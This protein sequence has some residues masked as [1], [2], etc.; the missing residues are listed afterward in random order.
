MCLLDS[1]LRIFVLGK[2]HSLDSLH[3]VFVLGKKVPTGFNP[4]SF[5]LG[6]RFLLDSLLRVFGFGLRVYLLASR[7]LPGEVSTRMSD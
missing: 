6:K 7:T 3:K 5:V 2:R 4:E 1:L